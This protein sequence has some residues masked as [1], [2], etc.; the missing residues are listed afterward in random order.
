MKPIDPIDIKKAIKDGQLEVFIAR[1]I[2]LIR[3]TTTGETVKIGE[4]REE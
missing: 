2:I 1:R 4:V 3:D